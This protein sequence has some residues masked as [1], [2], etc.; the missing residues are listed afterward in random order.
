MNQIASLEVIDAIRCM[1]D[2]LKTDGLTDRGMNYPNSMGGLTEENRSA[3]G[4]AKK[5]ITKIENN[6]EHKYGVW[7][8][9]SKHRDAVF[10]CSHCLKSTSDV[11]LIAEYSQ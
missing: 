3:Y 7:L 11:P 4:K 10:R 5:I 8:G 2:V 9:E 6:C 1:M